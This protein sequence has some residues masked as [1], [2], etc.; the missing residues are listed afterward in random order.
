MPEA[1]SLWL[2]FDHQRQPI[3][4]KLNCPAAWPKEASQKLLALKAGR[5]A[6]DST[7]PRNYFRFVIYS[8]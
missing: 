3:A 2:V 6:N 1:L 4:L 5:A 8:N 7:A